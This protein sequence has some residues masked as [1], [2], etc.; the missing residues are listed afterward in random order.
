MRLCTVGYFSIWGNSLQNTALCT[1]FVLLMKG[2]QHVTFRC[3]SIAFIT[4]SISKV[5]YMIRFL[6]D[7]E[8]SI[9]LNDGDSEVFRWG[10]IIIYLFFWPGFIQLNGKPLA[11][12]NF[13]SILFICLFVW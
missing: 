8:I 4:L 9:K 1:H 13:F 2:E 3:F 5:F 6:T 7:Y 12:V 11:I 10:L